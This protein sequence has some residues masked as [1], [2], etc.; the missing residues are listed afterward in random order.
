[1]IMVVIFWAELNPGGM[2]PIIVMSIEISTVYI[3]ERRSGI[4]IE[5][6]KTVKRPSKLQI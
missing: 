5:Q 6:I 1:M 3:K 4:V 2:I